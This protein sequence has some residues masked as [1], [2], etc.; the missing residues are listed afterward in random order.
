MSDK[1]YKYW[2][3]LFSFIPL[4]LLIVQIKAF[5]ELIIHKEVKRRCAFRVVIKHNNTGFDFSHLP[6]FLLLI[7]QIKAFKELIIHKEVKRRC[8]F[9]VVIHIA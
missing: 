8:A 3:W 9:R 4:L 6:L 5:K 7:V 1:T 2:F